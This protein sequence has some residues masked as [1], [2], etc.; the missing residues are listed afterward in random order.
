MLRKKAQIYQQRI[1]CLSEVNP[2]SQVISEFYITCVDNNKPMRNK[3][4]KKWGQES[5]RMVPSLGNCYVCRQRPERQQPMKP[6]SITLE[7][8]EKS[9]THWKPTD[10][11]HVQAGNKL[12]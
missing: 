10:G 4:S 2:P 5:R 8:S 9:D 7:S 1:G 3:P 6:I 11:L 12:M